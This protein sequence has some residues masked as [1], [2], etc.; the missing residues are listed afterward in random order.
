MTLRPASVAVPSLIHE[1]P[2]NFTTLSTS[3]L[4]QAPLE[5]MTTL[6]EV[7]VG[8]I[9]ARGLDKAFALGHYDPSNSGLADT[10]AASSS[11]LLEIGA[12]LEQL[13]AIA[14]AGRLDDAPLQSALRE[15]VALRPTTCL[16]GRS[17]TD[18]LDHYSASIRCALAHGRRVKQ[19]PT[20]W[21]QVTMC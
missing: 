9:D 20:Q 11:G 10:R 6:T 14:P 7:L 2:C 1:C 12:L 13:L 19:Q 21:V 8:W 5:A 16:S 3:I 17:V 4:A 15:A 18:F